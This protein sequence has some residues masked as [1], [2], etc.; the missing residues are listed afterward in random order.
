MMLRRLNSNNLN[1][2][3]SASKTSLNSDC[4]KTNAQKSSEEIYAFAGVHH[5]FDSSHTAEVTRVKF[6]NNDK[7]LLAT[8][9]LD[10]TLIIF[11]VIP[12]PATI[13]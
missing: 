5:I 10:G 3:Y 6:A 9:S 1:R 12:S 13:I 11:Q 7:S 2:K 8:C 4:S